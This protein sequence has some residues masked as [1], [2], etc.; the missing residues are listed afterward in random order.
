MKKNHKSISLQKVLRKELKDREFR[1]Y[2]EREEAISQIARMIRDARQRA[3]LTQ[4]ELARK[5]DTSQAV[6]ARIESA[7]DSRIPSL[8][9]LERIAKALQ[10]KLLIS[11]EYEKAA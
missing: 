3:R 6:I 4:T 1:F 5:A 7:A 9:L 11:F 2:F 10:A 8:D